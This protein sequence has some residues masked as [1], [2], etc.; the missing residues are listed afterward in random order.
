MAQEK[1][2]KNFGVWFREI[3]DKAEIIDYRF[4]V[5]GFGC[6]MPYGFKIRKWTISL[7]R[8]LLDETGHEEVLFP[9]LIPETLLDKESSHIK[10]FENEVFWATKGGKKRLEVKLALR[11]TSET[12]ITPMMNLWVRSHTGLPKKVYQIGSIYRHETKATTP[13]IR[14]RE[15]T[16]FKEAFTF[17]ASLEDADN[18]VK[19]AIE[20]YK[21]FF[22][23]LCIPYVLSERPEFDKFPGALYTM[24]FD[25][26][27]PDGKSLQI[28]TVHNLGQTFAKAFDATFETIDGKQEFFYQ[29]SYGISE[30][31]IA[32][33]IAIHGDSHGLIL[34]PIVAPIQV[35]VVP[36][37]YKDVAE[38]VITACK[39]ITETLRTAGFRVEI[40][41]RND[42][43]P[44]SKYYEWEMRG[45]PIRVELGPRDL[46]ANVVTIVR[47]DTLERFSKNESE[48]ISTITDLLCNIEGSLKKKA[49]E[50]FEKHLHTA[51]SIDEAKKLLNN[52][53]GIIA[54]S[55]CGKSECGLKIEEQTN[56]KTLGAPKDTKTQGSCP[57]CGS[58]ATRIIRLAR[59]Y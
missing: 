47:R 31:A 43:T 52:K 2:K 41:L 13:L 26:V 11:P 3:L 22:D 54:I 38:E 8:Q 36:I 30:R 57:V 1:T 40:D 10:G 12:V 28:G 35:I 44:G 7:L 59:S 46:K 17:H 34:P 49:W 24:A 6:W 20:V 25:T 29:T 32:A 33:L 53:A 14:V 37:T 16:T 55:W 21:R 4:P 23:K 39:K 9:S 58:N 5:K 19:E 15:V 42:L 56:G 27:F 45:V 18:Q 48:L 50:Q 51:L